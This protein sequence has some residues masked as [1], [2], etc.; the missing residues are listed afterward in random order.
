MGPSS[1]VTAALPS[2]IS[3]AL[4]APA[5]PDSLFSRSR[6]CGHSFVFRAFAQMFRKN[7]AQVNHN[8]RLAKSGDRDII[9]AAEMTFW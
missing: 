6:D 1:S 3:L 8:M 7:C 5:A 9:R 2:G 4:I